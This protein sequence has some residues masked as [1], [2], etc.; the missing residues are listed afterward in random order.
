MRSQAPI[1]PLEGVR[2]IPQDGEVA[3]TGRGRGQLRTELF[4]L[5][6]LDRP[7]PQR[8]RLSYRPVWRKM[9]A[10]RVS[11][12]ASTAVRSS[13][14]AIVER[15]LEWRSGTLVVA[16]EDQGAGEAGVQF[17]DIRIRP[18]GGKYRERRS[19]MLD[20]LAEPAHACEGVADVALERAAFRCSPLSE[21][22]W[23]E[24]LEQLDRLLVTT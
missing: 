3:E 17:R 14:S 16:E 24:P 8:S 2:Q 1:G 19:V 23:I 12:S 10:F 7:D 22:R 13:S 15:V 18:V 6:Q 9:M 20:R 4:S 21:Q 11:A 5:D